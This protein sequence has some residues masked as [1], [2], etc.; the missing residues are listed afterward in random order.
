M[1]R[2]DP[3]RVCVAE[4]IVDLNGGGDTWEEGRAQSVEEEVR[5]RQERE[6]RASENEPR[7]KFKLGNLTIQMGQF[8]DGRQQLS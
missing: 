1:L 4:S 8:L 5:I 2:S 3:P 6:A 7:T